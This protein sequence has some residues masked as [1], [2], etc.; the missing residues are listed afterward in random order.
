[1]NQLV[2]FRIDK[3]RTDQDAS[4]FTV[5]VPEDCPFFE[6][7]FPGRPILPAIGQLAI[8]T[9]LVRLATGYAKSL[10]GIDGLKLTGQVLPG[11]RL[12]VRLEVSRADGTARFSIVRDGAP[13]S[14]GTLQ[15][16]VQAGK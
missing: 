13:V 10:T 1:M 5:A 11:D 6:G 3:E 7:H 12:E 15:L 2:P 14:S 8:L 9:E 4:V 16:A